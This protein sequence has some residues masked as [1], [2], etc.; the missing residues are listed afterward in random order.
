MLESVP[1]VWQYVII[2]V[3]A[4]LATVIGLWLYNRREK[5]REHSLELMRLC[6]Q[7]GLTWFSDL[8]GCY[9]IGNYSKLIYK[10]KEIITALR[11]DQVFIDKLGECTKKVAAFYA[12]HDA[13]K[14]KELMDILQDSKAMKDVAAQFAPKV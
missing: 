12:E 3:G 4:L 6:D 9:A 10:V 8:Y 13:V 1:T 2:G 14:A 5:R 11:S 7:W